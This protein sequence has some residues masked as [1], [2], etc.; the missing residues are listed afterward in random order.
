MVGDQ[1]YRL[2]VSSNLSRRELANR[3]NVTV[4]AVAKWENGLSSPCA[5]TL[6]QLAKQCGVTTDYLLEIDCRKTICLDGLSE[7]EMNLVQAM[8]Q[9]IL[10]TFEE[11]KR[12][13][14]LS[15]NHQ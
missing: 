13:H 5:E 1:I 10:H 4:R 2:R 7:E 8:V 15:G 11:N 6:K 14:K 9:A 12:K 3:M